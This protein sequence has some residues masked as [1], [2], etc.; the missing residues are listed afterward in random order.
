MD[1]GRAGWVVGVGS[2]V[3]KDFN[4]LFGFFFA[5]SLPNFWIG[6]GA[7]QFR[8]QLRGYNQIEFTREP[9]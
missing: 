1:G 4:E 6:E 9:R 8:D 7:L 3:K 2:L 5:N